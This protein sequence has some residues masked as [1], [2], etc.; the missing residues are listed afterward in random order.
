MQPNPRLNIHPLLWLDLTC[1]LHRRTEGRHESG[2]FLLGHELQD[3]RH[4]SALVYYDE[5]DPE[6]YSSGICILHADAFGRLWQRCGDLGLVVVA[7]V[8]VHGL[9]AEQSRADREN[10]MVARAGHLAIILP[11]MA[12][13]PI[14]RATVGLYE[15]VG[16]H[17]WR[18]H[19]A[20]QDGGVL[21]IEDDK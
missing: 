2:A 10:P 16:D 7:D 17:Q 5:L 11:R 8:H 1:E 9:D 15:Y 6:A 12:R 4:A 21:N 19:D 13:P 18:A 20:R 14:K 3:G